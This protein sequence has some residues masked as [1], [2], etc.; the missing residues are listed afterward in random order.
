M[1]FHQVHA[2][3]HMIK[4]QLIAMFNEVKPKRAFPVHTENQHLFEFYCNQVIEITKEHENL[5]R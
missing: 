4:D 5:L 3:G 1:H 2:S